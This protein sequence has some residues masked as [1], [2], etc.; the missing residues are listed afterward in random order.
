MTAT[1]AKIFSLIQHTL[2]TPK[3]LS[4]H[5]EI[6]GVQVLDGSCN[7][8]SWS[9]SGYS[10]YFSGIAPYEDV[11]ISPIKKMLG[12]A[13]IDNDRLFT[14]WNGAPM[15]TSTPLNWYRKFFLTPIKRPGHCLGLFASVY[16]R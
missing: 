10:V 5:I 9:E 1:N 15:G 3:K 7:V 12:D 2:A 14:Q 6:D 4:A 11:N 16:F 13:W 8:Q